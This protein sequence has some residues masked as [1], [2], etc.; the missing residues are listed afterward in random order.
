MSH[1]VVQTKFK[2]GLT[3]LHNAEDDG[4]NYMAEFYGDHG[5]REIIVI[6]F[7]MPGPTI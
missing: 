6:G 2:G 4:V 3:I 1:I 5:T 7:K